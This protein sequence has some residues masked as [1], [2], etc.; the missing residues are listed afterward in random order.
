MTL[1]AIGVLNDLLFFYF[2]IF[3]AFLWFPLISM[4][5]FFMSMVSFDGMMYVE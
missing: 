4:L 2:F 1:S 5:I 3:F